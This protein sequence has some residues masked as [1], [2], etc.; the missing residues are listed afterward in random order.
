MMNNNQLLKKILINLG[1]NP[2]GIHSN[3]SYLRQIAE[4]T[5][6]SNLPKNK[7][8]TFYLKQIANNTG[9]SISGIKSA[10][11][12]LREISE[13]TGS[14]N[15]LPNQ[16][17]NYY[18][19]HIFENTKGDSPVIIMELT[20]TANDNELYAGTSTDLSATLKI[21]EE[22][23]SGK[24][25]SFYKEVRNVETFLGTAVTNSNG[26]AILNDGYTADG[27]GTINI[28]AKYTLNGTT[29]E[30]EPFT[31][32]DNALI[33]TNLSIN[34]PLSLIY[35]DAFNITGTL[36][37][38]SNNAIQGATVKLKVGNTVVDTD[39][40]DSNGEVSFTQTPVSTGTHTFQLV[41]EGDQTHNTST[42]SSV[43]RVVGKETS[44]L[45]LSAP[46][47]NASYYTDGN[48]IVEGTLLTDDGE[49]ISGKTIVVSENGT[50]L[51]TLTTDNDGE[52]Y[53]TITGLTAGNHVLD[54]DYATDTEYTASSVS[55][56]ITENNP[57]L[58]LTS[59]KSILSYADHESA[60]LTATYTG[61]SVNGKT[62]VF[63]EGSRSYST[64]MDLGTA[65]VIRAE[66]DSSSN[67]M[68]IGDT[69]GYNLE[70][71][72]RESGQGAAVFLAN[73]NQLTGTVLNCGNYLKYE[74]GVLYG[75]NSNSLDIS[76]YNID[77]SKNS[78]SGCTVIMDIIDVATTN[79]N[80][81]ATASYSSKGTG[82]LNIKAECMNVSETYGISDLIKYDDAKIYVFNK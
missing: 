24:T 79:N 59:D 28:I 19:R 32:T 66:A 5:G 38:N 6:S 53:G 47:D 11:Y 57:S 55:R 29:I 34:V 54:I 25:I 3:N 17:Q 63:S 76:A 62:V 39:T 14:V 36:L 67:F 77:M 10:I 70:Y 60:T 82:D 46:L 8:D 50:T 18:L 26:V 81:V 1:G 7:S 80:G 13:N 37:D 41:Y 30:S 12:C 22:L 4:Y 68:R 42:S 2:T 44:V 56:T 9:S 75:S 69:N 20:A 27:S 58:N 72:P 49:V 21:N 45:T 71:V 74:N 73:G 64:N 48:V 33:T 31:I 23:S 15:I 51:K 78:N 40:T 61:A 35:T 65:W 52:F 43:S 16:P